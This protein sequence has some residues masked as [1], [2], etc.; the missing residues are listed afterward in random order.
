MTSYNRGAVG[1]F[2]LIIILIVLAV[3]YIVY[4]GNLQ[5]SQ[6]NNQAATSTS[7]STNPVSTKPFLISKTSWGASFMYEQG[8]VVQ[9][10][11]TED[12]VILK[13]VGGENDGDTMDINFVRASTVTNTDAKFGTITYTYD[14]QNRI[15]LVSGEAD[16]LYINV[17]AED[18][19]K[20]VEPHAATAFRTTKSGL[21]IYPGVMRWKTEIIP[22]APDRII[23]AH[24][25]GSGYTKDLET[26]VDTI[27][28]IK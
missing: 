15:W 27:T 26:L 22:I 9:P 28:L 10:E 19:D 6:T 14:A 23:V 25:T 8:W 4:K 17:P 20:P 11:G 3:G 2:G 5:N 21:P 7:S 16:I 12:K 18:R 13:K 1:I 24:V